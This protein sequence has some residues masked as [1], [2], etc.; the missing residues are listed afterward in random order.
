MCFN[1]PGGSQIDWFQNGPVFWVHSDVLLMFHR[2]VRRI[3][4]HNLGIGWIFAN[5]TFV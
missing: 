3:G 5:V 2:Q 1:L 4:H